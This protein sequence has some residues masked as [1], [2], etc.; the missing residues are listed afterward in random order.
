M[1]NE[2]L[3]D[4]RSHVKMINPDVI[5][6]FSQLAPDMSQQIEILS[7][8]VQQ[9][10]ELTVGISLTEAE[11]ALLTCLLRSSPLPPNPPGDDENHFNKIKLSAEIAQIRGGGI[12]LPRRENSVLDNFLERS[13]RYR[14]YRR[15][16]KSANMVLLH[17]M[18]LYQYYDDDNYHCLDYKMDRSLDYSSHVIVF[19]GKFAELDKLGPSE[20]EHVAQLYFFA[21]VAVFEKLE[22]H[23]AS[24]QGTHLNRK[25]SMAILTWFRARLTALEVEHLLAISERVPRPKSAEKPRGEPSLSPQTPERFPIGKDSN[26]STAKT[27]G[28]VPSSRQVVEVFQTCTDILFKFRKHRAEGMGMLIHCSHAQ[29]I[30]AKCTMSLASYPELVMSPSQNPEHAQ[31][32]VLAKLEAARRDRYMFAPVHL[33]SEE[34][35]FLTTVMDLPPRGLPLSK[36]D[37]LFWG[38]NTN[39]IPKGLESTVE[40]LLKAKRAKKVTEQKSIEQVDQSAARLESTIKMVQTF[41]DEA[42]SLFPDFTASYN[43]LPKTVADGQLPVVVD[44]IIALLKEKDDAKEK[45]KQL[46]KQKLAAKDRDLAAKDREFEYA[47]QTSHK[48]QEEL[49][50]EIL[51]TQAEL[52]VF[53]RELDKSRK[54]PDRIREGFFGKIQKLHDK[55][56]GLEK[57]I[58]AKD[59][60]ISV[61]GLDHAE[62][63]KDIEKT[64]EKVGKQ[65]DQLKE[66]RDG[67]KQLKDERDI[68]RLNLQRIRNPGSGAAISV[69]EKALAEERA[70][71]KLLEDKLDK[72]LAAAAAVASM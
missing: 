27:L 24:R 48:R 65:R 41:A 44:V 70:K 25:E 3:V 60:Q 6:N 31:V 1:S 21:I 30:W 42:L 23:K 11:V 26:G 10:K 13:L 62:M 47:G 14:E 58:K 22:K 16:T 4:N 12:F 39:D 17:F 68:L 45:N 5:L 28:Q 52:E 2:E 59:D 36:D 50:S 67:Y 38:P 54:E 34:V 61:L 32:T 57:D 15:G 69:L 56:S 29:G 40:I 49:K 8:K 20:V 46:L 35:Q 43:K 72:F 51:K 63:I 7:S 18:A 53:K 64:Q 55:V 66:W 19:G 37:S 71:S 9:A 33:D